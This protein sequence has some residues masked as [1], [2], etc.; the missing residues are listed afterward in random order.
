MPSC[1][2][3]T[4]NNNVE[5]YARKHV[6]LILA[7]GATTGTAHFIT[8]KENYLL[9]HWQLNVPQ[10]LPKKPGNPLN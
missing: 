3:R 1:H 4:S 9:S 10:G 5:K 8:I 7:R 2:L 6:E